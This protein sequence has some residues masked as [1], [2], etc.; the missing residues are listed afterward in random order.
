MVAAVAPRYAGRMR[1][2]LLGAA[3]VAVLLLP[4]CF[5]PS[6]AARQVRKATDGGTILV[7]GGTDAPRAFRQ[8]VS[9]IEQHCKGV[10]EV[11]EIAQ[12]QTGQT[13]SLGMAYSFG[14]VSMGTSGTSPLY[15]TSITYL[16]RPPSS[17][18]LNESVID[19]ATADIV[20]RK[21]AGD[22]D[23]GPL[24]CVRAEPTAFTGTC[25][26]GSAPAPR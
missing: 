19:L 23:C 3:V 17:T 11:V 1:S 20:G 18:E 8:A 25:T 13:Q 22:A 15:A 14:P 2:P 6:A 7:S 26:P 24:F 10:Y 12:V 9:A 4:G 21:C 16:C 5:A